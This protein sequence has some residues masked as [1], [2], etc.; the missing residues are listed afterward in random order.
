MIYFFKVSNKNI[1]QFKDQQV[2]SFLHLGIY[3]FVFFNCIF[4]LSTFEMFPLYR[5]PLQK[6]PI[7]LLLPLPL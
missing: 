3:D 4:S 7:P 2:C 5:S 6:P 1:T